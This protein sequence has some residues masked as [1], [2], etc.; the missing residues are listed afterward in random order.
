MKQEYIDDDFAH[1]WMEEGILNFVYKISRMDIGF[2]KK[3]VDVR[4]QLLHDESYPM[5][6]DISEITST[7]KE[8]RDY[9]SQDIAIEN[10]SAAALLAGSV[11]SKV[12]G[13]FF[14]AFNKPAIPIKIFTDRDDAIKWLKKYVKA[15]EVEN[16]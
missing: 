14:L 3:S 2:A 11:L 4:K 5:Y 10:I 15:G 13:T 1:V 7:S 12:M 9:L 16:P 6:I 8:A